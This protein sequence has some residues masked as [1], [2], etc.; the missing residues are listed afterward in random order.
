MSVIVNMVRNNPNTG[1]RDHFSCSV[2]AW[3]L[4][5]EL[6][7]SFE[8]KPLGAGYVRRDAVDLAETAVRHG[9]RPGDHQD[10]KRVEADDAAAWAR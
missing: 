3:E 10:Y 1:G 6:G 8:W 4:L 7:K 9:Y 5:L 2:T